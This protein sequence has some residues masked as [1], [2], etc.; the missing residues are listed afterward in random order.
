[1]SCDKKDKNL[2]TCELGQFER[3]N[4]FY[5][6]LMTVRDFEAEQDYFNNKRFLINRMIHGIGIICGLKVE[7]GNSEAK[8]R[9]QKDKNNSWSVYLNPGVAL[10][11]CGHEIVVNNGGP[12]A[13]KGTFSEKSNG[14]YLKYAEC[15]KETVLG[16][17][18][19]SNCEE[20]CCPS[21]IGETFTLEWGPL[22]ELTEISGTVKEDKTLVSGALVEVIRNGTVIGSTV[23]DNKGKYYLRAELSSKEDKTPY[24]I[25]VSASNREVTEKELVFKDFAKK[26]IINLRRPSQVKDPAK[27][28]KKITQKYYEE[29]LTTCPKCDDAKVLLVVFNEKND[30]LEIN[31]NNTYE[32]REIV[33]NNPMLYDLLSSHIIDFNNPHNVTAA[34]TGALE[35]INGVSGNSDGNIFLKPGSENIT[36]EEEKDSN[37]I[38]IDS[39]AT[40]DPAILEQLETVFQYLRERALKCTVISFN[41]LLNYGYRD[42]N[43][44]VLK[45]IRSFKDAVDKETYKNEN[46]TEFDNFF[47]N[48][49]KNMLNDLLTILKKPNSFYDFADIEHAIGELNA[50]IDKGD[51]LKVAA[52]MTEVCFYAQ[53]LR[54]YEPQ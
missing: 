52:A 5:G 37:A 29:H 20:K 40:F 27:L 22:P 31:K 41:E 30:S 17:S 2:K 14:L 21:R 36:I 33:Y 3:N 38:I 46:L 19:L 47:K 11:C 15:Q 10:D 1:M 4:Y 9:P 23:T 48:T 25:R 18:N 54:K 16:L 12:Y 35:S 49:A 50:E 28:K 7:D 8:K 45:I 43:E 24:I 32:Y 44:V 42:I 13:V 6:K 53:L 39:T 26:K 34:Q 51:S